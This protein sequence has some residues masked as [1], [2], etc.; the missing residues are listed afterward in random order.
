MGVCKLAKTFCPLKNFGLP[1]A[2]L[3]RYDRENA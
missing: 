2:E 3:Q 1:L